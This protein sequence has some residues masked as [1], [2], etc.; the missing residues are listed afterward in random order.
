MR[1]VKLESKEEKCEVIDA[2]IVTSGHYDD[3]FVPDSQGM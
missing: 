3:P 2:V 1:T